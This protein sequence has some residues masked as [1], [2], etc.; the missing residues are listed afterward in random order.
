MSK[1][2]KLPEKSVVFNK[3]QVCTSNNN[4]WQKTFRLH[5]CGR[6]FCVVAEYFF[7]SLLNTSCETHWYF[8]KGLEFHEKYKVNSV[9][10]FRDFKENMWHKLAHEIQIKR[11]TKV[12]LQLSIHNLPGSFIGFSDLK[13]F[14][15]TIVKVII[16]RRNYE[17]Q[18]I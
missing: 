16:I 6:W 5:Q 18:R 15:N 10:L 13:W 1:K 11:A 8:L 3:V 2:F 12:I 4:L 9:N 17:W 14:K 7:I